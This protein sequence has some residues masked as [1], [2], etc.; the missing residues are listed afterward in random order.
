MR[1]RGD[2]IMERKSCGKNEFEK[3]GFHDAEKQT[4]SRGQK[5]QGG[6][7]GFRNGC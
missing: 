2:L 4:R 3:H 7:I 1:E 6:L 5:R